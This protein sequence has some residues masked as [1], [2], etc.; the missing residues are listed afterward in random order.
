MKVYPHVTE[1][2]AKCEFCCGPLHLARSR[3]YT[4]Q[5]ETQDLL[6]QEMGCLSARKE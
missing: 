2:H 3:Q 6:N 1:A 4:Y 5:R